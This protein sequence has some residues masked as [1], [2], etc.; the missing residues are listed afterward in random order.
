MEEVN[1]LLE[2]LN[3]DGLQVT[4]KGLEQSIAY[5]NAK[6]QFSFDYYVALDH[7]NRDLVMVN[8]WGLAPNIWFERVDKTSYFRKT[9]C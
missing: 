6:N 5:T 2:F 3:L 1:K 4:L 9:V 8:F 7:F